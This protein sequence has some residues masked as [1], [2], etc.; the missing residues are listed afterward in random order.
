MCLF[1]TICN[2]CDSHIKEHLISYRLT[3]KSPLS[4]AIQA[5]YAS[6]SSKLFDYGSW[7]K[8]ASCDFL[9]SAL[10]PHCHKL[11]NDA[12]IIPERLNT[13]EYE[14]GEKR[15]G[16]TDGRT[17]VRTHGKSSPRVS[18]RPEGRAKTGSLCFVVPL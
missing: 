1:F 7:R 13:S 3:P 11:S 16:R 4:V 18:P 15:D 12:K 9:T 2:L 5:S 8:L 6:L 17:D 14:C 10:K